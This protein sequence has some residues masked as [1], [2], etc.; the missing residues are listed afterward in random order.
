MKHC[1]L[2]VW[3]IACHKDDATS[4]KLATGSN[5]VKVE[6]EG[7]KVVV[8][9]SNGGAVKIN[10]DLSVNANAPAAFM[11][12]S[13]GK[14][15]Q[16]CPAKG[17]CSASCSGGTCAQTCSAGAK[18]EFECEG[19][20]CAQKCEAGSSCKLSCSGGSCPQICDGCTKSC[21]GSH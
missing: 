12:C 19:G 17:N 20:H 6:T 5:G 9:G 16:P 10:G 18:C 8:S 1:L 7:D 15:E 11:G 13:A 2:L 21:S 14:C 4:V 3:L